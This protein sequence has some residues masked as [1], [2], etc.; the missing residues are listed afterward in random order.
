MHRNFGNHWVVYKDPIDLMDRPSS[1]EI[2]VS[3]YQEGTNNKWT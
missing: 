3:W 1:M 2:G